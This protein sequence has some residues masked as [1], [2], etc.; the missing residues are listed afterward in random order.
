MKINRYQLRTLIYE[1]INRVPVFD[2]VTR[3]EVRS[4][5]DKT[6]S[7]SRSAAGISQNI[8]TK[9]RDTEASGE[10]GMNSARS[11]AQALGSN[12]PAENIL[13]QQENE[14]AD[15]L[16]AQ[17]AEHYFGPGVQSVPH[18]MIMKMIKKFEYL[19][20]T[21]QPVDVWLYDGINYVEGR[22][23]E[24][25]TVDSMLEALKKGIYTV[26]H[27]VVSGTLTSWWG[28][29]DLRLFLDTM[30]N[31]LLNNGIDGRADYYVIEAL[32]HFVGEDNI[33]IKNAM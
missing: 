6:R 30:E 28:D 23:P 5:L 1:A 33:I 25:E 19:R 13:T 11:L 8:L 14:Y 17:H 10:E 24:N 16:L 31:H 12:S 29:D 26:D 27:I 32:I 4:A 3:E 9:L 21:G 20:S 22:M 7:K 15:R 18:D 2:P